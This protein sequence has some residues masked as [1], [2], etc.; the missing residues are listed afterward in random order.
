[1]KKLALTLATSLIGASTVVVATSCEQPAVLCTCGRGDFAA[2]YT[3]VSGDAACGDLKSEI[4][5]MNAYAFEKDGPGSGTMTDWSKGAVAIG[6]ERIGWLI[7]R[8][9]ASTPPVSDPDPAHKLYTVGDFPKEPTNDFCA[10]PQMRMP[11]A[12]INMPMIPAVPDDPMTTDKDESQPQVEATHYVYKWSNLEY[13]VRPD[14]IGTQL[15]GDLE[16][17]KNGC[18]AKYKVKGVYPARNCES[19]TTPGQPDKELCSP[20]S[21]PDKNIFEGSGISPDFPVDC[22]EFDPAG[23][24]TA[25]RFFCMITKDVPAFK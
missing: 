21:Q 16:Y 11:D 20:V 3:F 8:G 22:V 9:A 14:A 1:M 2:Q 5:G 23:E 24:T 18:T 19:R 4:L 12:E 15:R 17:T 10:V 25:K 13:L 6:S 7:D